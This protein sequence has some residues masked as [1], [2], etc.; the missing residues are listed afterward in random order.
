M[1]VAQ[2]SREIKRDARQDKRNS[3]LVTLQQCQTEREKWE[4]P[5]ILRSKKIIHFTK[6]LDRHGNRVGPRQRPEAI[7]DLLHHTQW[8]PANVPPYQH[9]AKILNNDL[10]INVGPLT[11]SEVSEAIQKMKKGKAAGH[12]Q[13]SIDWIKALDSSNTEI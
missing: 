5:K 3:L 10:G 9:R 11:V 6:L 1:L 2:L 7:A 12:D 8:T 13:V 4:G